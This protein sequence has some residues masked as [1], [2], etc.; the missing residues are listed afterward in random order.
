MTESIDSGGG[1]C[2]AIWQVSVIVSVVLN[3]L[4]AA[5]IVIYDLNTPLRPLCFDFT[6]GPF[7]GGPWDT[8]I[9]E[10][11]GPLNEYF[12]GRIWTGR[13]PHDYRIDG[14]GTIYISLRD[15]NRY[16]DLIWNWTS[17]EVTRIIEEHGQEL[18]LTPQERGKAATYLECDIVRRVAIEGTVEAAP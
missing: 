18:A 2:K 6:D 4:L 9:E 8:G 17:D 12:R 3:I 1:W 16:E 7:R 15:R 5:K 14:D 13:P 11:E 10:V